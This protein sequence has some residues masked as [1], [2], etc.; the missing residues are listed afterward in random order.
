[1]NDVRIGTFLE[2]VLNIG[3]A[4][5]ADNTLYATHRL[6]ERFITQSPMEGAREIA[7]QLYFDLTDTAIFPTAEV[8]DDR[9]PQIAW[10]VARFYN[11]SRAE[12]LEE[13]LARLAR[14]NI[15]P[16]C[17]KWVRL[18]GVESQRALE[19]LRFRIAA[20]DVAPDETKRSIF[21]GSRR[22]WEQLLGRRR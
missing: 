18:W 16:H 20:V 4:E 2:S 17:Q 22:E 12:L 9:L 14:A 6:R 15:H 10:D 3:R 21:E 13:G 1:M 8:A 19:A 11:T 5:L 7:K